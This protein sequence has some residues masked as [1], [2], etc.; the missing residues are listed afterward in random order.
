MFVY[1]KDTILSDQSPETSVLMGLF[2]FKAQ[3]QTAFW[4]KR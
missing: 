1:Y 4:V 2:Q 3:D